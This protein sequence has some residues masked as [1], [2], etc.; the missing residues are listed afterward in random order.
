MD[1]DSTWNE[2][3]IGHPWCVFLFKLLLAALFVRSGLT[4]R[5]HLLPDEQQV[6]I[7]IDP[8]AAFDYGRGGGGAEGPSAQDQTGERTKT[9][10]C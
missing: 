8:E 2:P 7:S 9:A 1:M 3:D 5:V 6:Q 10:R 4:S